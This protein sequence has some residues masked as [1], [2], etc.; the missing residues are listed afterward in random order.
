MKFPWKVKC[1]YEN[2]VGGGG[3]SYYT[4]CAGRYLEIHCNKSGRNSIKE[5]SL[6]KSAKRIK[7]KEDAAV[8]AEKF[9]EELGSSIMQ[10]KHKRG[11][12]KHKLPSKLSH[13]DECFSSTAYLFIFS[14]S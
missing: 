4:A 14:S 6:E 8:K 13:Q 9:Q 3:G 10:T 1:T 7:H 5:Q 11:E 2:K 12:I